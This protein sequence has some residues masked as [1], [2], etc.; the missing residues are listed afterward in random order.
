MR[1][2]SRSA[3]AELPYG[4]WPSP[5]T[6]ADIAGG[7][8]PLSGGHT[9]G[10]ELWW[11]EGRPTEGGRQVVARRAPNGDVEA[12]LPAPWN[13]R[14]RVHEYGGAA[15]IGVPDGAAR[16][17]VFVNFADQRIWRL[18]V[19]RP[20]GVPVP[21]TPEP[22]APSALRYAD[23]VPGAPG[24]LLWVREKH[25]GEHIER[26]LVAVPVDASAGT[27][28]ERVRVIAGGSDFLA[29]PR[30]SP[31]GKRLAWIAWDHP[32]MPWDGTELRVADLD[33][34]GRAAGVRTLIGG[35]E[36]SVLQPTW[37]DG[38]ALY[39]VSDRSGWWNLYRI[40][41]DGGVP[42]ALH[43]R[44]EEFAEPAW[45]FGTRTYAGLDANR[46]V[47]VHGTETRSL[48]ILDLASGRLTDLDLPY[49]SYGSIA[50]DGEK[51]HTVAASPTQASTL[52]E[53]DLIDHTATPL[54]CSLDDV[55][56]AGYLSTPESLVVTGRHG[57]DVHAHVYA[58][59]NR[60]VTAPAGERP[61]YVALVHG[62]P[63]A[64]AMATLSLSA[65]YFT[66]RGIGVIDVNYGGSTGY[67]REYRNRLRGQWG[68]IDVEDTV[69]ACEALVER[70][71]ADP[72]RLAIRG[73]SAGGWTVLA[74][75][76]RTDTFGAGASYF[77][78][79]EL[80]DF[81]KDTHDFESRYIDSLVG[82]LPEAH[83][84]YVERA[85]LSHVDGVSCP[86]LLLQGADDKVVPPSQ[87]EMFR[88][89][90]V[91]KGIPHA[92]LLFEGEQHGFRKA[93]NNVTALE[94]ELSFYGQVFGFDPPGVPKLELVT[95]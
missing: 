10:G 49:T 39:V 63:T 26:H 23:P 88:D 76:T 30:L 8:R 84:L 81:V 22:A 31:D 14:S 2:A 80:L 37:A 83:D 13:V 7:T 74:A 55:P 32:R 65:A 70:G 33:A 59:A 64:Q 3:P 75:L 89:A 61:P 40:A 9:V 54:R 43:Q 56:D 45:T 82:P 34:D 51:L 46:I 93:E 18:D 17:L 28:P 29:A 20:G 6:A 38:T 48:G 36:E 1:N 42:K 5:L 16:A 67:G 35:P 53:I 87:A 69:T 52:V 66:S 79:A 4:S 68:V 15:W 50:V 91:R 85:P 19:D 86:V 72:R 62:G 12:L 25:D 78:V 11:L 94:A 47:T 27:D 73:G 71:L 57:R 24:E 58:P 21:L 41:A 95:S 77:G 92:Y 90:L 60:D 44:A